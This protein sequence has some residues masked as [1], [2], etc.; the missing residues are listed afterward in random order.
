[1]KKWFKGKGFGF[2]SL[3]DVGEYSQ[4]LV[5]EEELQQG[6]KVRVCHCSNLKVE[7]GSSLQPRCRA[8]DE[9]RSLSFETVGAT[10]S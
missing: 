6:D 4:Q 9:R 2:I 8:D 3:D 5:G 7:V 1:M 10:F